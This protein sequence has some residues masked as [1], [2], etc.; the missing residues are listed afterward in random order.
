MLQKRMAVVQCLAIVTTILNALGAPVDNVQM[1]QDQDWKE[2]KLEEHNAIGKEDAKKNAMHW[3][4]R[5]QFND[6]YVERKPQ[7]TEMKS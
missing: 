5:S 6:K 1:Y 2:V 4:E 3:T 7:F